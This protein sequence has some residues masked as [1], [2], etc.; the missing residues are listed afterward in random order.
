MNLDRV[1]E[2][3]QNGFK[4]FVIEMSR[5]KRISVWHPEFVIV[6]KGTVVVMGE[7]DSLTTLDALHISSI[8]DRPTPKTPT[9]E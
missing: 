2:R 5:G 6:G 8:E 9:G 4:P 7:D 1:R 3:L